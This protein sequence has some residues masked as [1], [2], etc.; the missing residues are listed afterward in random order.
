MI[1]TLHTV[2]THGRSTLYMYNFFQHLLQWLVMTRLVP[3]LQ[4]PHPTPTPRSSQLQLPQLQATSL[5]VS[6]HMKHEE[7]IAASQQSTVTYNYKPIY[8]P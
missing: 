7:P 2:Q 8:R 3:Q 6:F 1:E 4:L 5:T